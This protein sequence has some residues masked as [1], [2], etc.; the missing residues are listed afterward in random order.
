MRPW[1]RR[2]FLKHS[3]SCAAHIGLMAAASPLWARTLWAAQERFPVVARE[4]WGRLERVAD[5]IWALVST[6]LQDRTTLCNGGIVAGRVGV[7]VVEAFG[8]DA[9]ARWM[10][11]QA[12]ALTG[13][14]ATHVV[15]THYH[16]DHTGGLRGA[17]AA[18]DVKL[19]ATAV[20]RDQTRDRNEG[21]PAEILAGAQLLDTRRPTEINL[22]DRSVVVVPRRGHTD[23]DV[24]LEISDP[25]VIF[26]GDLV[27]NAMF[28]NY[29]DAIPSRLSLNVRMLQSLGADTYVPGHGPLAGGA[30]LARYIDLLD[31][32]EAAAREAIAQGVEAEEAGARYQVPAALGEWTLFNPRYFQTAIGAWIKELGHV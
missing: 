7:L 31:D 19:L 25:S 6:P 27:W 17:F 28:P 29:M 15:V 11:E 20:T 23:S 4:P 16:G 5:G 21:S 10:A 13:R 24:S 9:G 14:S 26:C 3:S 2:D 32:V 8:S 12:L 30:A 18:A 22:G 1:S